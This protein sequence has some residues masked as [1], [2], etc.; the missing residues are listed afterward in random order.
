MDAWKYT[1]FISRVEHD[2]SLIRCAHSWDIM[3]NTR[4]KSGIS[5]HQCII[6]YIL[7]SSDRVSAYGSKIVAAWYDIT[8]GRVFANLANI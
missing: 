1:R 7:T 2:I 6:L 5:A 4:N 3:F 8:S